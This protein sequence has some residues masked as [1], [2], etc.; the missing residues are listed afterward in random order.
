MLV[1]ALFGLFGVALAGRWTGHHNAIVQSKISDA[2]YDGFYRHIH[3]GL[4]PWNPPA[5]TT[6]SPYMHVGAGTG[7]LQ[8]D[9]IAPP[10][11]NPRGACAAVDYC[12]NRKDWYADMAEKCY[13]ELDSCD[14]FVGYL[15]NSL[16]RLHRAIQHQCVA[17]SG[18]DTQIRLSGGRVVL[19]ELKCC[20]PS[21]S[22]SFATGTAN[23]GQL[24]ITCV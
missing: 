1:F 15:K 4:T 22:L 8:D 13:K 16:D 3:C 18:D 14:G 2:A 24:V 6:E 7:M 9:G 23:T 21:K 17:S 12:L 11:S 19:A 5:T 10:D 20:D